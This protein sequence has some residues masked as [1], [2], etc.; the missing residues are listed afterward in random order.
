MRAA[1]EAVR[2]AMSSET[3]ITPAT[4]TQ[5][6]NSLYRLRSATPYGEAVAELEKVAVCLQLLGAAKRDGRCNLF[7]SQAARLRKQ[8]ALA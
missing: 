8:I 3:G 1:L 6:Q 2:L 7:E 4:E 5:V